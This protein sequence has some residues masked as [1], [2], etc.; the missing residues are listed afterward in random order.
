MTNENIFRP[1]AGEFFTTAKRGSVSAGA[2][3]ECLHPGMPGTDICFA[4][5]HNNGEQSIFAIGDQVRQV[6]G[7]ELKQRLF[8][9]SIDRLINAYDDSEMT[10]DLVISTI[11][12]MAETW[13]PHFDMQ[14]GINLNQATK[15]V[16]KVRAEIIAEGVDDPSYTKF[17]LSN[18]AIELL[19][20]RTQDKRL[21]ENRRDRLVRGAALAIAAIEKFDREEAGNQEIELD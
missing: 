5:N 18:A 9:A 7:A 12:T 10:D 16:L 13:F 14:I 1:N 11:R 21:P 4:L 2:L 15:D 3:W 19:K 8:R 20:P 17:A 6:L